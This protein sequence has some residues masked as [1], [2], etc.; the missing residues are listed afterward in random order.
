[1]NNDLK[2]AIVKKKS[3]EIILDKG[4]DF[5]VTVRNKNILHKI[6]ILPTKRTIILFPISIGSMARINHFTEKLDIDAYY[7][8]GKLSLDEAGR[9]VLKSGHFDDLVEVSALAILNKARP[10][11]IRLWMLKRYIKANF[12]S[13]DLLNMFSVIHRQ[14]GTEDLFFCLS[15]MKMLGVIPGRVEEK[16][17]KE[18]I[19]ISG[20]P[21]AV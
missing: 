12:S 5:I 19:P 21:Q 11:R 2:D 6:G 18:N 3:L 17:K 9:S 4:V 13:R 10:S 8:D 14:M 1:M 7:K 16:E 20:L 15:S